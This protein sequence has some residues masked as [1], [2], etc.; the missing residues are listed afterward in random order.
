MER[1]DTPVLVCIEDDVEWNRG[2]HEEVCPSD[3]R[4]EEAVVQVEPNQSSEECLKKGSDRFSVIVI[5]IL[6]TAKINT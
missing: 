2:Y 3:H 6:L 5:V 1:R 4:L